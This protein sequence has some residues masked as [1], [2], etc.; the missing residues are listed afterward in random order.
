VLPLTLIT[1]ASPVGWHARLS[2]PLLIAGGV[3]VALRLDS[4]AVRQPAREGGH[5]RAGRTGG[6]RRLGGWPGRAGVPLAGTAVLALA[7]GQAWN[8]AGNPSWNVPPGVRGA[9]PVLAL[10]RA[11]LDVRMNIGTWQLWNTAQA[12]MPAPARSAS[13]ARTRPLSPCRTPARISAARWSASAPIRGP[14]T[15]R[16]RPAR[17]SPR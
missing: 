9:G 4:G 5:R 13:S 2:I 16:S 15:G 14:G 1:V 17:R 3:A 6:R 7:C 11:P 12:S 8:Q 10:T